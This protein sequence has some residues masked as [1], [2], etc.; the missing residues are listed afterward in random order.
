MRPHPKRARTD[1]TSPRAWATDDRSGFIGNHENMVW[2]YQWRGK[3]LINTKVLTYPDMADVPQR[4]LGILILPPDPPPIGNARPEQYFIDEQ[5][6]STRYTADG[7]V[8]AIA[9]VPQGTGAAV[10]INRIVAVPGN[11]SEDDL[12]G[13]R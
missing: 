3:S 11:L 8:R 4:Q 6:V 7:R 9:G 13:I 2:N 10:T 5:P 1:P 12:A